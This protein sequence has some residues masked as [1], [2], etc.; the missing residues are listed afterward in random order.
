MDGVTDWIVSLM[1]ALGSPGA[2]LLVA[3]ESIFPPIPSELILPLAG[4]TASQG[5]LNVVAAVVWT[6]VGSLVGALV[7]YALGAKVGEE[8]LRAVAR[9]MPLVRESDIDTVDGWFERH[10]GKAVFFGRMV[11]GVRSLISIPAGVARMPVARFA[12]LSSL[13]SLVWNT[14]LI[15]AGYL[16]GSQWSVVET[17][18]GRFQEVVVVLAVVAVAVVVVRR[19]RD[20]RRRAAPAGEG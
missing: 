6:T 14:L 19:V 13:G 11:P 15:S 4:F 20:H 3:L 1:N 12:L 10:G 16:L 9:R 8:R 7:L 17:W 2:G 18:V 5:T